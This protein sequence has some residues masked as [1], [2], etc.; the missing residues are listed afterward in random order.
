MLKGYRTVVYNAVSGLVGIAAILMVADFELLGFTAQQAAMAALGLK[1]F[2]NL[3]N[4]LLRYI[5]TTPVGES[6]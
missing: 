6:R 5:T 3:S 2:D 4:L 1:I